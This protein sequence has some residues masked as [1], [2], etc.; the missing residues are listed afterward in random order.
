MRTI[1]SLG[2]IVLVALTMGAAGYLTWLTE[3]DTSTTPTPAI[4]PTRSGGFGPVTPTPLPSTTTASSDCEAFDA[5]VW[6]QTAYLANPNS[7]SALD[8]DGNGIACETLP[9]NAAA[10]VLWASAIPESAVAVTLV[11]VTDG[12]TIVVSL[13]GVQE[14][15][16]LKAI[17]TP[18]V[19]HNGDFWESATCGGQEATEFLRDLLARAPNGTI[20][21]EFDGSQRDRYNRLLA[22]VWLEAD[23]HV[24]LAEE[25]LARNGWG[26]ATT[27]RSDTLYRDQMMD[28]KQ[29]SIDHVMGVPLICGKFGQPLDAPPDPEKIAEARRRQPDQGQFPVVEPANP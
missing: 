24:Y 22:Y 7:A 13:N 25:A 14:T 16:R 15:V 8:P 27:Y 11:R 26:I 1:R 29:F 17:D 3:P 12:D 4:E 6:A 9:Y 21:L 2:I 5:W 18:E 28:A 10:P 23:G 20:F 19:E